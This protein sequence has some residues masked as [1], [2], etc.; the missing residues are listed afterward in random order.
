MA[1]GAGDDLVGLDADPDPGQGHV[2]AFQPI[3]HVGVGFDLAADYNL[4]LA[5]RRFDH[6]G[7]RAGVG[8]VGG[9]QHAGPVGLHHVLHDH[10]DRRLRRH[11][12][13]GA[14]GHHTLAV[15]RRPARP[16]PIQQLVGVQHVGERFVHA[17]EAR[18]RRVLAGG[19]GADRYGAR[20]PFL[21][22][23]VGAEDA[24]T[25]L[26]RHL[27]RADQRPGLQRPRRQIVSLGR[28][29]PRDELTEFGA[30]AGL[31]ERVEKRG[32]GDGEARGHRKLGAGQLAEVGRLATDQVGIG[33]GQVLEPT[34][35]GDGPGLGCGP[36]ARPGGHADGE[37]GHSS[38]LRPVL[39]CCQGRWE[40][41]SG[42]SALV[43][44]AAF[45]DAVRWR[46]PFMDR[47]ALAAAIDHTLLDPLARA[48]D[49]VALCE[50]AAAW[51]IGQVCISPNRVDLAVRTL[52]GL[53]VRVCAVIGF[54]S[55]AHLAE[56]K[57]REAAAAV[58]AGAAEVDMVV[59][60]GALA[61]GDWAHVEREVAQVVASVS[62]SGAT[63]KAILETAAFPQA[64]VSAAARAALAGGA[65]WL[66]TSTG[67][68][69]SGGAT[70]E[71]VGLLV[72]AGQPRPLVKASGGIRTLDTALEFLAAGAQRLGTSR[73]VDLLRAFEA[74]PEVD[75][76]ASRAATSG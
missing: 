28:V 32:C 9:E 13:G 68:H 37:I 64:T 11:L 76:A 8:G 26:L 63:V 40:S 27:H 43:A 51:R 60:L 58:L 4:S 23:L 15:H 35:V 61:D 75:T 5:P 46:T 24:V 54:P 50:D 55:G 57:A 44:G 42:P 30:P 33:E 20:H 36:G 31:V 72:A 22:L 21:E 65:T 29:D 49:V 62:P 25:D 56:L 45:A 53:P 16:D 18:R 12:A 74:L 70:I 34:Y 14:V 67:Y 2:V 6:H 38:T 47:A 7:L 10:R 71:T 66:K 59:D 48:A 39:A 73:G 17:G 52:A 69:P 19:G 1:V 3:D 41:S